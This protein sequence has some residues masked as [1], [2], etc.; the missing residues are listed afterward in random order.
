MRDHAAA[1]VLLAMALIGLGGCSGGSPV[2]T[3]VVA[4]GSTPTPTPEVEAPT[5]NPTV[6][7]TPPP[8]PTPTPEPTPDL[9]AIGEAYLA[10][11]ARFTE[12]QNAVFAEFAAR[13][14][15]EAEY[16]ALHQRVVDVVDQALAD[17]DAIDFPPALAADIAG[18]RAALTEIRDAFEAVT[19]DTTLD[20][21]TTLD[22]QAPVYGSF[23]DNVRAY[24]GLPPRPT[25][26]P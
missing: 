19:R 20:A 10:M 18:M 21:F 3:G 25:P 26:A 23:A 22:E 6:T 7:P 14:H 12:A 2:T 4:A 13:E 15:T 17:H 16:I 9:G 11:A 8:T 5:A 24:L 1:T